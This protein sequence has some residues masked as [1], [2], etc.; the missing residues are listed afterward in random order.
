MSLTILHKHIYEDTLNELTLDNKDKKTIQ[1]IIQDLGYCSDFSYVFYVNEDKT[2]N[3]VDKKFWEFI[4]PKTGTFCIVQTPAGDNA[5]GTI[6]TIAA[7]AFGQYYLVPYLEG[8]GIATAIA[9]TIVTVGMTMLVNALVPYKPP[10]PTGQGASE[11]ATLSINGTQNQVKAGYPVPYHIGKNR[12]VPPLAAQPVREANGKTVYFNQVFLVGYAP[13]RISDIKIGDNPIENFSDVE[14]Q[15]HDGLDNLNPITTIKGDITSQ[16]GLSTVIGTDYQI[17][18]GGINAEH[19]SIVFSFPQ[20]LFYYDS[21]NNK[22]V[23]G[24]EVSVEYRE[25]GTSTWIPTKTT[26]IHRVNA[27]NNITGS[28]VVVDRENGGDWTID[29]YSGDSYFEFVDGIPPEV[30][31]GSTIRVI[32]SKYNNG[33]WY[34]RNVV[35][36]K[37]YTAETQIQGQD[38]VIVGKVL[39]NEIGNLE[40][41]TLGG[42]VGTYIFKDSTT[43][44]TFRTIDIPA[45]P[46]AQYEFRV[47]RINAESTVDTKRDQL[48]VIDVK[49]TQITDDNGDPLVA[50]PDKFAYIGVRIKATDQLNG[51]INQ[52]SCLV[53]SKP[54]SYDP[55]TQTWS[56]SFNNTGNPAWEYLEIM[57]SVATKKLVPIS[58]IDLDTFSTWADRCNELV[59]GKPRHRIN[60]VVDYKIMMRELLEKVASVG[61]AARNKVNGKHSVILDVGGKPSVQKF[62]P[63]NSYNF[64]ASKSF[65]RRPDAFKCKFVNPDKN[66]AVDYINIKRDDNVPDHLIDAI[67]EL[68]CTGIT[69]IDEVYRYAKY[70]HAQIELRPEEYSFSTGV[71]N[72]RC[73]RGD[74]ISVAHDKI[75]GDVQFGRVRSF[76]SNSLTLDSDI[77][78]EAGKNYFV[79]FRH[80]VQEQPSTTYPITSSVDGRAFSVNFGGT[81]PTDLFRDDLAIIGSGVD[82]ITRKYVVKEIISS[83]DL[84]AKIFLY[85]Y[86]DPDIYLSED[87][88]IPDYNPTVVKPAINQYAAPLTPFILNYYSDDRAI[89]QNADGSYSYRIAI[90]LQDSDDDTRPEAR[91]YDLYYRVKGT[92]GQYRKE[93]YEASSEKIYCSNVILD[94]NY[95][96]KVRSIS[97]AG[98]VSEWITIESPVEGNIFPP[99]DVENFRINLRAGQISLT[100]NHVTDFDL[101]HY[102]IKHS[103]KVSGATWGSSTTVF[104]EVSKGFNQVTI[105]SRTGT[106]L[107]KAV[108][109]AG[110][111]ST[112][113]TLVVSSFM[114]LAQTNVVEVLEESPT[115]IGTKVDTTSTGVTLRLSQT[116]TTLDATEGYYYFDNNIDLGGIYTSRVFFE[117]EAVGVTTTNI[118]A[119]WPVLSNL[120]VIFP[121]DPENWAV[122][123]EIRYKDTAIGSGTWSAWE[124]LTLSEYKARSF[125]FR[126]RLESLDGYTTPVISQL[127]VTVDMPDRVEGQE[128]LVSPIGGATILYPNGSFKNVPAVAVNGQSLS[129]GDQ[130]IISS[131][132]SDSFHIEFKD[133][134]G[135]SIQRTFDFIAKGYGFKE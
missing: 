82:L 84:T 67:E 53:E 3:V 116:G 47:K 94:A 134:G 22:K 6:L 4:T 112:N 113:A 131:R 81:P 50:F 87:G 33:S 70:A 49:T 30:T 91:Y 13:V 72:L 133:S 92:D 18:T 95:E 75:Q 127:S 28:T 117:M 9:Q 25:V 125:E 78:F 96:I 62:T 122:T 124:E 86:A 48:V 123:I 40:I 31:T 110:N 44:Q 121:E 99:S 69:D 73:T 129:V 29:Q 26:T 76:T 23:Q 41:N 27:I 21:K 52:L 61:R 34:I 42:G 59:N 118:I 128:D 46:K 14:I 106:F 114:D 16:S 65:V 103:S 63:M 8:I 68:D 36:N 126:A 80:A 111:E 109:Y 119:N 12:F 19:A 89:L 93:R 55:N 104:N 32:T 100:W 83:D 39:T 43:A 90:E 97:Q 56:R 10:S 64:S 7:I 108:D 74:I 17:F 60:H 11:S 15:I 101:S 98:S 35:G 102:M 132:T 130:T 5:L 58:E 107:I 135:T 20:G 51:T 120:A 77:Y 85:D 24:V 45:L 115:F 105:P 1:Q 88:L 66:W 71:E 2:H 38:S 79:T 54:N 57:N 37:A